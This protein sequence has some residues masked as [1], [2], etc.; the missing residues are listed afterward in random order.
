MTRQKV[1][2]YCVIIACLLVSLIPAQKGYGNIPSTGDAS[3][4]SLLESTAAGATIEFSLLD[5]DIEPLTPFDGAEQVI[6]V[7]GLGS[8]NAP[9]LPQMPVKRVMLGIPA[10]S[11]VS[12][13]I[14]DDESVEIEG[15]FDLA[16]VP[17]PA[18]LE[19]ASDS[20]Q[21]TYQRN[22][23]FYQQGT[24]Y[25]ASIA[26]VEDGGWLR[27]IQFVTIGL[28]PFQYSPAQSSIVWH[29]RMVIQVRFD[30]GVPT[31]YSAVEQQPDS[32]NQGYYHHVLANFL[33]NYATAQQWRS[34]PQV[35]SVQQTMVDGERLKIVVDQDGLYRIGYDDLLSVGMAGADPRT[36]R[37][38]NQGEEVSILVTGEA[39][40]TLDPEDSILF[41]GEKFSGEDM[42]QWY[43]DESVRWLSYT[44]QLSDGTTTLWQPQFNAAM[45]EKY[46]TENVYWLQIETGYIPARIGWVD[47]T[48]NVAT[49]SP[50]AYRT[51]THAEQQLRRWETHFTSEDT[52]FWEY[53]TDTNR[54]AYTATLSA[55]NPASFTAIVRSEYVAYTYN[56][57]YSPDHHTTFYINDRLDPINDSYWDGR[58]RH[59]FEAS[60]PSTDLVEGE[61]QLS[62][63]YVYDV[64]SSPWIAFD[65]FEIEYERLYV[66]ES[67]VLVYPESN[68]GTWRYVLN[69]FSQADV[70]V[71]DVTYPKQP[72]GINGIRYI[73]TGEQ[74][75]VEFEYTNNAAV[76]FYTAGS[77]TIRS[78]KS[79]ALY[80]PPDLRS[81]SN[82]ADY[83][84]IAPSGFVSEADTLAQYRAGQGLRAQVVD[85]SDVYNEFNDG[86]AHPI[87]I[88][89]FLEYT[90]A[91]WIPPAPTYV[92]LIGDGH[93]NLLGATPG[94]Y[95][96]EPV[97]MPPNLGWVDPWQGEIDSMNLL[98]TLIGEDPLPDLFIGRIPVN[99]VQELRNVISKIFAYENYPTAEWQRNSTLIA[100]NTPDG[101][102]D[103]VASAENVIAQIIEPE[104]NPIRIYADDYIDTGLCSASPYPGGPACPE[105]NRAIVDTLNGA[106]TLFLSYIG[107]AS[108]RNWAH[109]QIFLHHP[110]DPANP[111]DMY[112]S[113]FDSLSNRDQLPIV[114]AMD[115]LDGYWFHPTLQPSMAELFLR[116]A[117]NGAIATYSAMGLGVGT[118]HDELLTGF[119]STVYDTGT[120]ELG[121]ASLGAQMEL[122]SSMSIYYLINTYGLFG[123]PAL[124]IQNP[125]SSYF[126]LPIITK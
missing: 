71:F 114:L 119:L 42:A 35:G 43:S 46:T 124:Q 32:A 86:I 38:T 64:Y 10:G 41:F 78:P 121:P 66:A 4:V 57:Y 21:W 1:I 82:G 108:V 103:F 5:Y 84:I 65:W 98:A 106:G 115:C 49:P 11:R 28:Y 76:V 27:D 22:E 36:Y 14:I 30:G 126:Y 59:R 7:P 118:G 23:T 29:Q 8:T 123:D 120:W 89:N 67:D 88:K 102:G 107:H 83:L 47:G 44:Q 81:S 39:D 112:Y 56:D 79:I 72:V 109:E 69:G 63:Q 70:N 50:T 75:Q 93:W 45:M 13:S 100:D 116:T 99:T 111:V 15:A 33:L 34:V 48:P 80:T 52:W 85:L 91:Y 58:S 16:P 73:D 54:H 17:V 18:G 87:A 25:P 61:N 104:F 53:V 101:A 55:I 37:M 60:I 20:N 6:R 68:L 122:Y 90:F 62:L 113:D 19:G 97:Y 117:E 125:N 96:T 92:V 9:G 105:I 94:I 110:D 26:V 31:D 24:F 12:V 2:F 3:V 74:Y 40:G 51:T 77:S 95:G